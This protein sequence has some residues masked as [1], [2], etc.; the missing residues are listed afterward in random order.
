MREDYSRRWIFCQL[1]LIGGELYSATFRL[2]VAGRDCPCAAPE[3]E[4][5]GRL[6]GARRGLIVDL[7]GD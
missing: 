7:K 4:W 2:N 6:I 5:T 3:R 1:M